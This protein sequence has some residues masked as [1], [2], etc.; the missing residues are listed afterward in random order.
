VTVAV[1]DGYILS[2]TTSVVVSDLG[3][4]ELGTSSVPG[5]LITSD[6]VAVESGGRLAGNGT[7]IGD[8]IVGSSP[9]PRT[10]L[11]SPGFSI[12]HI[13]VE[14]DLEQGANGTILIELEGSAAGQADTINV[15][16]EAQ[17]GGTL[18]IDASNLT[19]SSEGATYLII[20]AGEL[21]G[22]F[23]N[24]ESVGNNEIYFREIYDYATGG[25]GVQQQPRGDMNGSGWP[26]DQEDFDLFVFGLM[27]ADLN[28]W[29]TRCGAACQGTEELGAIFPQDGGDFS[30]NGRL[31]FDDTSGFQNQLGGMGMS[32]AG[33]SAAFERYFDQVPE[34]STMW[35]LLFV[36]VHLLT[37]S[38]RQR[39]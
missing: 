14:G 38:A 30:G 33:L 34:P 27:N 36:G 18:Q 15:S 31:D 32:T 19:T 16:G 17:L 22:T 37:A 24:V 5:G 7:V 21:S 1:H 28:E 13:E 23:E 12:G 10:A 39:R 6:V 8:L 3:I 11:L 35:M 25:A 9:G 2:A 4:V 29:F 26:P 20:T